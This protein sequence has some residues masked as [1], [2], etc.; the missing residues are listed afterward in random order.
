M[1][2]R[3]L[4]VDD[5]PVLLISLKA[6]LES[7]GHEVMTAEDGSAALELIQSDQPDAIICDLRMPGMGGLEFCRKVRDNPEWEHI[8]L[9]VLTAALEDPGVRQ[10]KEIGIQLFLPKPFPLERLLNALQDGRIDKPQ[11]PSGSS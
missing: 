5:E 6:F 11:P 7:V 10:A 8:Y 4:L 9:I 2:R 3:V 1:Y